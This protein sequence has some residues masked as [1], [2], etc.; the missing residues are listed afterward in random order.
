[1]TSRAIRLP[2]GYGRP[3]GVDLWYLRIPRDG[4]CDTPYLDDGERRRAARY[5]HEP[6]RRRFALTRSVLRELLGGYVGVPPGMLRFSA[7]ERGRP[8]LTGPQRISFNVSHSGDYALIVVSSG[9]T[10]GIDIE[11]NDPQLEWRSLVPLVCTEWEQCILDGLPKQMQGQV[12]FRC[13]SAKEAILKALGLGITEGLLALEVNP[14][15]DRAQSPHIGSDRRFAEAASFRYLWLNDFPGYTACVAY[16]NA[17][18][19]DDPV[20]DGFR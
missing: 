5:R 13:W 7:L 17:G 1:M 12:F 19:L 9:R 4:P 11:Y 2:A 10:V 16:H 20:A 6:D 3:E 18:D 14:S 15:L 8:E